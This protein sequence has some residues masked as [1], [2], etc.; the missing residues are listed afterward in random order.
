MDVSD[1]VYITE[2]L[3]CV[4]SHEVRSLDVE[5]KD[6]RSPCPLAGVAVHSK[7]ASSAA[8]V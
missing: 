7:V 8:A 5:G 4:R 2:D 6:H 3:L 1:N